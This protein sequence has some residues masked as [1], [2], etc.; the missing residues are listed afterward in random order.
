MY[1]ENYETHDNTNLALLFINLVKQS[2]KILSP[3]FD[4]KPEAYLDYLLPKN[5]GVNF[6]KS[7]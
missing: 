6:I 4:F 7:C 3:S 5:W 1:F 2:S